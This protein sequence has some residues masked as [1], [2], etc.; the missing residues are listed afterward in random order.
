M[1]ECPLDLR[2]LCLSAS[3]IPERLTPGTRKPEI[4]SYES[5]SG[6]SDVEPDQGT[7]SRET[8]QCW[9]TPAGSGRSDEHL[10]ALY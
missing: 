10:L 7:L 9:W 2:C 5:A 4:R 6:G 3:R 1:F 8:R